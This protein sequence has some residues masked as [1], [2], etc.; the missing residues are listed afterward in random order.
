[1]CDVATECQPA[2][3]PVVHNMHLS[4]GQGEQGQHQIEAAAVTVTWQQQ[5]HCWVMCMQHDVQKVTSVVEQRGCVQ[6]AQINNQATLAYL[7]LSKQTPPSMPAKHH[8]AEIDR[9]A[10]SGLSLQAEQLASV[11][12]S[13]RAQLQS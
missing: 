9:F 4:T 13:A 10:S 1:M 6:A 5:H 3:H 12:M 7:A 11:L 8:E 2:L